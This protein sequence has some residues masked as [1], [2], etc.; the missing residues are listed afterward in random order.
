M[1]ISGTQTEKNLLKAFAG[2]SQARNRYTYF[3]Q[4]AK[5]EGHAML[6][7][8]FEQTAEHERLHAKRFFKLLQG[9]EVQITETF[10]AGRIG[11]SIENLN[12]SIDGEKEEWE[13]IY[14][15][16]AKT[17]RDEGFDT[18]AQIFE[19]IIEAEKYHHE[20]FTNLLRKLQ[21][22]EL[23]KRDKTVRWRC[24]KCGYIHQ[25]EVAPKACI[26]C[27]HKQGYFD[28]V[29]EPAIL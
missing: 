12:M 10:P 9:G 11:T 14:P 17:A 1:S 13:T 20:R 27:A 15:S 19:A 29:D 7:Q 18:I 2:E 22:G 3:A 4:V 28:V 16:F 23:Y 25:G 8:V 5:K 6:S 26:A 24:R 21:K